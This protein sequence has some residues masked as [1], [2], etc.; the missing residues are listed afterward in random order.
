MFCRYFDKVQRSDSTTSLLK[1][2]PYLH[3]AGGAGCDE[4]VGSGCDDILNFSVENF[5]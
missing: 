3:E 2:A 1:S 4:D 5:Q